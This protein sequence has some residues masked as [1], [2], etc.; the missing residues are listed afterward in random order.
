MLAAEGRLSTLRPFKSWLPRGAILFEM[1]YSLYIN[2]IP[3]QKEAGL[4]CTPSAQH[5]HFTS[6]VRSH[7]DIVVMKLQRALATRLVFAIKHEENKD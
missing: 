7:V 5:S 2:D 3:T 1:A 6:D 4:F